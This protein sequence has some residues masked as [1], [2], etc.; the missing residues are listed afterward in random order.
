MRAFLLQ[1]LQLGPAPGW[2]IGLEEI[3]AALPDIEGW[4]LPPGAARYDGPA[5]FVAGGRSGYVPPGSL[6]DIRR[7]FPR[8]RLEV[9]PEAGHWLHADQPA[10][11]NA[12]VSQFL[13]DA[14]ADSAFIG[15][16]N[17]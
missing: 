14:A 5:L 7:L 15:A 11:F 17:G 4:A 2:K 9:L 3:A 16:G 12:C 10:L 8:A 6:D 1:N 13:A